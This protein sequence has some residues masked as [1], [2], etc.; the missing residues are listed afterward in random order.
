MG[1]T[2][3]L[4]PTV[5]KLA[6]ATLPAGLVLDGFD[7]APALRGSGPSP[8]DVMFFYRGTQL[9]AARRGPFKAHFI[10]RPAYGEGK[11]QEH[12][13][14]LVYNLDEDPS[15]K[16]NVAAKHPQVVADIRSVIE[17]HRAALVPGALQ[18]EALIE[19]K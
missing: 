16:Y 10:T 2:L 14:P 7:I 13:P 4:L 5:A 17:R 19:K 9:Y 11:A 3:D 8:R 18:L 6:G 12:D 1:S 15:E